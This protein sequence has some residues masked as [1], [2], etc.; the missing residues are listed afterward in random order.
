M[1]D[2]IVLCA[3]KECMLYRIANYCDTMPL[4]RTLEEVTTYGCTHEVWCALVDELLYWQT[5][6]E[7]PPPMLPSASTTNEDIDAFA[8]IVGDVMVY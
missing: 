8:A 5:R 1:S 3:F 6:F 4:S 7:L 2:A